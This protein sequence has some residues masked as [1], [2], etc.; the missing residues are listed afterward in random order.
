M[1]DP[2]KGPD[3]LPDALPREDLYALVWKEPMLKIA[4]RFG[5]SSSYLARV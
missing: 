2:S 4:G 3:G 5:V 1:D